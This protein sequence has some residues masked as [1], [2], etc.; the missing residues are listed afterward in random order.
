MLYYYYLPEKKV[1][2]G[3]T[4]GSLFFLATGNRVGTGG[5]AALLYVH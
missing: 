1:R 3:S 2:T 5:A 4:G